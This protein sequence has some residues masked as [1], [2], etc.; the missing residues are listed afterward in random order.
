MS[1]ASWFKYSSPFGLAFAFQRITGLILLLYLC[2]HLTYLSSLQNKELYESFIAL[3]VSRQFFVLDS[4]LILCGVFH[5]INGLRIVLHEF[6][7]AHE[8]RKAVLVFSVA[9]VIT[10]WLFGSYLL[11]IALGD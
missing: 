4:L 8:R 3:T 9:I 1:I 10:S 6:G 2:L 5:G 11:Y 7:F